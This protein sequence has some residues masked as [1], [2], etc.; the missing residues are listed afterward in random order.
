MKRIILAAVALPGA[1]LAQEAAQEPASHQTVV[2]TAPLEGRRGELLQAADA[3]T[4]TDILDRIEVSIGATLAGL[5]GVADSWYGPGAGR[6]VIRGLGDERVRVL[7]NGIGAI[8]A[9]SASPDHAVTSEA[10]GASRIEV[11][12]GASALAYGGNAVGGVVNVIDRL[13]LTPGLAPDNGFA[14]EAAGLAS[15]VDDGWGASAGVSVRTGPLALRLQGEAR[16]TG[17]FDVPG[18]LRSDAARRD[19]PLP[20]AQEIRGTA[21]NSFTRWRSGGIGASL[22]GEDRYLGVAVRTL[23]TRYGL[24][25]HPG[26]TAGGRIVLE[27]DR[28]EARGRTALDLGPFT[29]LE[30]AGQVADYVHVELEEDGEVGVRFDSDGYELRVELANGA[31][32]ARIAGATGVQVAEVDLAAEGEEAFL[33]ASRTRDSAIFTV[34]RFDAGG[35]GLEGGARLEQR[36]VRNT[37][38]ARDRTA[39]SLSAG[40]FL[41]TGGGWFLSASAARTERPPSAVELFA[42]GP[43]AA[44]GSYE[45]GD[46]TL[47]VETAT[48]LDLSARYASSVVRFEA[49]LY[50]ARFDDFVALVDSGLVWLEDDDMIVPAARP[51]AGEE[52][53][54]VL[55]F[56]ARDATFTGGEVLFG[57][58]LGQWSGWELR[59]D[60]AASFV[61]ASFA[62]GGGPVPRIPADTVTIGLEAERG[63]WFGR[64][65]LEGLA[66]QD[67]IAAGETTTDGATVVNARLRWR[68]EGLRGAAIQ[69]DGRNL[70]DEEVRE[71]ASFLK[72]VLPKPGRSVRL[73]VSADF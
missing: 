29:R 71:H 63:D 64:M 58:T 2:V 27:Q 19:D 60:A 33:T 61:R 26:E 16:E 41:R 65:E 22:I 72:D 18:F 46:R 35:W 47:D 67:R 31:P 5:P 20:A 73:V 37:A 48:S 32:G 54:P 17:D 12:K 49:S 62:R 25:P 23:D 50:R 10:L 4:R 21:P 9:S 28:I 42:D 66:G 68:P 43:H 8:D 53:L 57:A 40:A 15:S 70:T 14:G 36:D 13:I 38:G 56:T 30:F 52:A 44:T 6:P 45:R 55:D 11:L 69:L 59:G 7:Q 34:Q 51:P 39:F 1:A 3:L 24:P